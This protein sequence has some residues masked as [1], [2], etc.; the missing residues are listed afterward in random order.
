MK[1]KKKRIIII[2]FIA[3]FGF[4]GYGLISG[5]Q[6]QSQKYDLIEVR[7]GDIIQ[8]VVVT[9]RVKPA[10]EVD[11]AFE[12]SGQ[13]A[14]VRIKV[15]DKVW[16][17]KR[18]IVLNGAEFSAQLSQ[19]RANLASVRAG[20]VQY[21]AVKEREQ[22]KLA[23]LSRGPRDEEV[24]V[25]LVRAA[26]ARQ[27]LDDARIN[28]DQ[29]TNKV[30]T[31][32]VGSYEGIKDVLRDAT[33]KSDDAVTRQ[34]DQLFVGAAASAAP[35]LAF[36]TLHPQIKNEVEWQRFLARAELN[37]MK[38]LTISPTIQLSGLEDAMESARKGMLAIRDFLQRANDAVADAVNLPAATADS[39][40]FNIT[41]ALNNINAVLAAA[42]S[43]QQKIAAQ[44]VAGQNAL[45]AAETKVNEAKNALAASEAELALA[46]VPAASEEISAQAAVIKE[47][48]ANL[49]RQNSLISQ[50]E[51]QVAAAA[52]RLAKTVLSSP[53]NGV[54]TKVEI[55]AGEIAAPN[56]AVV[57][58]ISS[59]KFEI[60]ANVAEADIAKIKLGDQ[61]Q[62]TLDAYG[63]EI[64]FL[65]RVFS[66]DPAETVID[67]VSTYK[68]RFQFA[69]EDERIKS[70]LTA[71]VTIQAGKR[72]NVLLIP[73][74]VVAGRDQKKFVRVLTAGSGGEASEK[75]IQ[76]GLK[77]SDGNIEITRGL[78][79][80][81]RVIA[82]EKEKK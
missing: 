36:D 9:G 3:A 69:N 42:N 46:K 68:T 67:G 22:A 51:A 28:S 35:Q 19:A 25:A 52:A 43:Q 48:S 39:Y 5:G 26:S 49:S 6:N 59:A 55:Q 29:T 15:G 40:H 47:A 18:L 44:K 17:G 10:A 45:A 4:I 60:E 72:E 13:V 32:L 74:R 7:R 81:E 82:G 62:A 56:T 73:Q 80:G 8:E 23:R 75:E 21:Q 16:A 31:D 34:V 1:L 27:A 14:A 66:I 71:N 78:R 30:A 76:V 79:E 54:A 58:V 57:T 70:G 61:A 77:G 38:E 53:L 33:A 20:L 24:A 11:L 50:A 12:Q 65:A 41:G 37:K 63:G 64:V 2:G